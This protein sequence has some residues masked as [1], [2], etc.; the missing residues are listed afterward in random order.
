VSRNIS[1]RAKDLIRLF[2]DLFSVWNCHALKRELGT[3]HCLTLSSMSTFCF[4]FFGGET[5]TSRHP[6]REPY[7]HIKIRGPYSFQQDTNLQAGL[8]PRVYQVQPSRL[9]GFQETLS[10]AINDIGRALAVWVRR[11]FVVFERYASR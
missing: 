7:P 10:F 6:S 9:C 2:I 8:H 4:P 3:R 1:C 11:G 5:P